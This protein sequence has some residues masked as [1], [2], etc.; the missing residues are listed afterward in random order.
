MLKK[1]EKIFT[2]TIIVLL[3]LIILV[4]AGFNIYQRILYREFFKTSEKEFKIPGLKDN[5]VPQGLFY[6]KE[7][8]IL[9]AC[10]YMSDN[11]PS[12]IYYYVGKKDVDKHS[13]SVDTINFEYTQLLTGDEKPDLCH[14]GG[15]AVYKD[16]VFLATGK[17]V[18]IYDINDILNQKTATTIA[19]FDG[20]T[21]ACFLH[22]EGDTLYV[23]EFYIAE[24]YETRQEHH[25]TTPSGEFHQALMTAF[26][27]KE[28][29][30]TV[31]Q[32]QEEKELTNNTHISTIIP[33]AAYSITD[34]AQGMC[35]LPNGEIAI[36]ISYAL[37]NSHIKIY[38]KPIQSAN[39]T[40]EYTLMV[41]NAENKIPLIFL[42]SSTTKKDYLAQP[43]AEEI[44]YKDGKIFVMCESA[45][46]KYM[47]GNLTASQYCY[48][49]K[50]EIN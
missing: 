6:D 40:K 22:I 14:A 4:V 39:T 11:T 24:A 49:F 10:G 50:P 27:L 8:D 29:E 36:S 41:D 19:T 15:I 2:V 34:N 31:E 3:V 47:F 17:E 26:D 32:I 23:G 33:I 37:T 46:N 43:M 1:V 30:S 9:F 21:D 35:I 12:R 18:S 45:C 5:Y 13:K 25:M 16:L 42:D 20:H 7:K 44:I 48:S 28:I 38:K